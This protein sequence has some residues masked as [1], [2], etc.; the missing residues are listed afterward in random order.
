M[1]GSSTL[2]HGEVAAVRLQG[3]RGKYVLGDLIGSGSFSLVYKAQI[4][5]R[6]GRHGTTVA[7]KRLKEETMDAVRALDEMRG[8]S[9][10]GDAAHHVITV[11]DLIEEKGRLSI[12]MPYFEHA[13]F[14][15]AL[16]R[17]DFTSAHVREYMRGLVTGLRHIHGHGFIHRDIKP[18]NVLYNF[19][20]MQA[21]VVDFGLSQRYDGPLH[22]GGAASA[23]RQLAARGSRPGGSP[24][25]PS[26][27]DGP[28]TPTALSQVSQ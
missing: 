21:L 10:L 26:P 23:A 5:G 14:A 27:A 22:R 8:L 28:A 11:L 15:E 20:S 16:E 19:S 2:L 18:N 12:V 1:A 13:D 6:A 9:F 3:S 7:I 4:P 25:R 24:R 17:G